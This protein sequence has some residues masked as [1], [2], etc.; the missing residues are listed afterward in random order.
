MKITVIEYTGIEH[1]VNCR[2][3]EFRTNQVANW[4]RIE[5]DDGS[6]ETIHGIATIKAEWTHPC[7]DGDFVKGI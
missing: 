1:H 5:C 2:S 4:I 7:I 6:K 3:F